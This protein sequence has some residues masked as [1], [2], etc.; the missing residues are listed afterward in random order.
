MQQLQPSGIQ[1]VESFFDAWRRMDLRGVLALLSDDIVYHNVPFRPHRGR[2]EVE[3]VL[4]G[5]CRVSEAFYI[6]F[7]NIAERDGVVLIERTDRAVGPW[8]DM[9]FWVCGTFEIRDGKIA[10]WRDRFDRTS[11]ALELVASPFRR[12]AA[13][14]AS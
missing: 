12:L 9:T 6:T 2:A 3:P 8:I 11:I 10:V 7:H 5:F 1:I 13:R 4:R 14:L